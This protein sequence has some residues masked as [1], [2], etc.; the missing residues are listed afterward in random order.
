MKAIGK[1]VVGC[2][3]VFAVY[4]LWALPVMWVYNHYIVLWLNTPLITYWYAVGV[5]FFIMTIQMMFTNPKS[6]AEVD[7]WSTEETLEK[8]AQAII[9]PFIVWGLAWIGYFFVQ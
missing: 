2:L 1:F 4:M 9:K 8:L 7:N 6:V 5:T 3:F